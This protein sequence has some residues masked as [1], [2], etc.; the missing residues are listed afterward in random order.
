MYEHICVVGKGE[1]WD[2]QSGT[3]LCFMD[4][5]FG[6]GI[7]SSQG[8]VRHDLQQLLQCQRHNDDLP[9]TSGR[10]YTCSAVWVTY[11]NELDAV[12][13]LGDEIFHGLDFAGGEFGVDPVRPAQAY[14]KS[15]TISRTAS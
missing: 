5:E 14:S 2:A 3:H 11:L 6:G 10:S 13:D 8:S 4:P 9:S 15:S 1:D 12:A 7:V